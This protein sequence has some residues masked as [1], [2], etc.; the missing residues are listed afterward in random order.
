MPC[1]CDG[2]DEYYQRQRK[3]AADQLSELL[4]YTCEWA[5]K[6]ALVRRLPLKVQEWWRAHQRA[7]EERRR[8]ESEA[9][10]EKEDARRARAKLTA[11]E[12]RALG[13]R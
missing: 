11:A 5:E 8:Q 7:D 12:R 2:M 1:N 10:R 9:E 4:C 13:I 3:D 6:N